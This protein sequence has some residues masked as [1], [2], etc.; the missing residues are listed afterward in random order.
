MLSELSDYLLIFF[1]DID[2]FPQKI[3]F[4]ASMYLIPSMNFSLPSYF[5]KDFN[6]HTF[7]C[8]FNTL[9]YLAMYCN[10]LPYIAI[11]YH[12]LPN[13]AIVLPKHSKMN[14]NVNYKYILQPLYSIA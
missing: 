3:F 14:L 2:W 13:F 9:P 7:T 10:N 1:D 5:V 6:V 4:D 8:G 11:F 12:T